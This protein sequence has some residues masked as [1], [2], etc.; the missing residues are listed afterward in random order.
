MKNECFILMFSGTEYFVPLAPAA[1]TACPLLSDRNFYSD[2]HWQT[3]GVAGCCKGCQQW[4]VLPSGKYLIKQIE[5]RSV[6]D[7][8]R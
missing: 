8:A 7:T 6:W 3:P 1:S 2:T 4:R 5:S